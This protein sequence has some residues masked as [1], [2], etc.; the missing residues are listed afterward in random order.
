MHLR[1][2]TADRAGRHHAHPLQP[3]AQG[4]RPARR[5]DQGPPAS[6]WRDCRA[7][8]THGSLHAASRKCGC[9]EACASGDEQTGHG[10]KLRGGSRN[11]HLAKLLHRRIRFQPFEQVAGR[12]AGRVFSCLADSH[13]PSV[14]RWS[15]PNHSQL[16]CDALHF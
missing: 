11:N 2:Q 1:W 7:L 16:R 3:A 4:G 15:P 8:P 12:D 13:R 14:D 5:R 9:N 6:C 10:F